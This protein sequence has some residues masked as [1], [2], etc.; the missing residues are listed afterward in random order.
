MKKANV[1]HRKLRRSVKEAGLLTG[2]SAPKVAPATLESAI[3]AEV[4]RLRK[5][6]DLTVT[7]LGL[8]SGISTGMLSKIEKGAVSPSLSTLS[9]LA[10]A[11]TRMLATC[12]SF[13]LKSC[14][15]PP[16]PP[17]VTF[18]SL[19]ALYSLPS[20]STTANT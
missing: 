7:E 12:I 13:R 6:F 1:Q 5:S 11:R 15:Q 4:R 2:S 3:G 18:V 20:A 10:M 8:T 9:S 16:Q 17:S 19:A 14:R